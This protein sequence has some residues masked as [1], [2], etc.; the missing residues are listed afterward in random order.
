MKVGNYKFRVLICIILALS[1][2]SNVAEAMSRRVLTVSIRAA[3]RQ[4]WC[5]TVVAQTVIRYFNKSFVTQTQLHTAMTGN[6]NS[7]GATPTQLQACLAKYKIKS[8]KI[9]RSLS[10]ATIKQQI[11]AG[12][13][14]IACL[15][16]HVVVI[17]GF[18]EDGDFRTIDYVDADYKKTMRFHVL[19]KDF[20]KT[21]ES[22]IYNLGVVR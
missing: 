20:V 12:K 2:F 13:P 22:T 9:N 5:A 21:W 6:N 7:T 15:K 3:D 1:I 10:F 14:V 17:N 11:L 8:T 16:H 19:Y 18:F 4:N